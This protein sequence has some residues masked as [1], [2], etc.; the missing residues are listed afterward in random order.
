MTDGSS[1]DGWMQVA[2]ELVS[3][4][5]VRIVALDAEAAA[6]DLIHPDGRKS[7]LKAA[8]RSPEKT[9]NLR[10][11]WDVLSRFREEPDFPGPRPLVRHTLVD[12]AIEAIEI[13]YLP[14]RHPRF[15]SDE[16]FRMMGAAIAR[17][18]K[19]SRG[20]R[21]GDGVVW[22]LSRIARH[23]EN[24][25]LLNLLSARQQRT[26][27]SALERFGPRFQKYMDDGLWTGLIHSDAHRHNMVLSRGRGSLIDFGE[28]GFGVVFYDLAVASADSA[29]DAPR[30]A[31]ACR[32]QLVDGYLSVMPDAAEVIQDD[33]PIFE[34]MRCLE[35]ITWPVSDWTPENSSNDK[36]EAKLNTRLACRRLK[37]L[38]DE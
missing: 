11:Q 23:F 14:G 5:R 3:E 9:A 17:L 27:C 30:R 29:L 2:A 37:A 1:R 22:D 7:V 31:R 32:R 21:P 38:L 8:R 33:L 19:L 36:A 6:F 25:C 24:P 4:A 15:T 34:A 18:H 20:F 16:D 10:T 28:S 13:S 12:K 35:I 26:I